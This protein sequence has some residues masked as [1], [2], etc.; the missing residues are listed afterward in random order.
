MLLVLKESHINYVIPILV[1]GEVP[2]SSACDI[3][4]SASGDDTGILCH[5]LL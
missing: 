4:E 5:V 2:D 3:L 1:D